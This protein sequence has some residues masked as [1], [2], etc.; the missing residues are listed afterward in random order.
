M[1]K[2]HHKLFMIAIRHSRTQARR[3][4]DHT[5][6]KHRV[7]AKVVPWPT[8]NLRTAIVFA[9]AFVLTIPPVPF[10]TTQKN[11]L[12]KATTQRGRLPPLTRIGIGEIG[13]VLNTLLS[14]TRQ[15]GREPHPL[16]SKENGVLPW[17]L[18]FSRRAQR[19]C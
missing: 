12:E 6:H 13:M 17:T 1:Y 4:S 2:Q 7:L 3:C 14:E 18:S 11:S 15:Y 10:T 8:E 19:G 9:G 16:H 5:E